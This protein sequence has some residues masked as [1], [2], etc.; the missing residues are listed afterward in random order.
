[1]FILQHV[2]K[3]LRVLRDTTGYCQVLQAQTVRSA[4]K[5]IGNYAISLARA[6]QLYVAH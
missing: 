1:M 2:R 3:C 6:G 4:K 5:P